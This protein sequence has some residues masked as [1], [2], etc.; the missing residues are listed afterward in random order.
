M[1]EGKYYTDKEFTTWVDTLATAINDDNLMIFVGAGVSI[2]QGYPNWDGYVSNFAHFWQFNIQNKNL[3]RKLNTAELNLFNEILSMPIS[4]KRKKDLL[5]T[6]IKKILGDDYQKYQLDFEK[7]YF[8]DVRPTN[9]GNKILSSLTKLRA[10]FITTNYDYEI[11]NHIDY[12]SSNNLSTKIHQLAA[13][14]ANKFK[15]EFV[16]NNVLHIHGDAEAVG[17]GFI[18]SSTSYV[19][20]YLRNPRKFNELQKWIK[21]NKPVILFVGSSMEEDEILALLDNEDNDAKN[22][23]F[24]KVDNQSRDALKLIKT[25]FRTNYNTDIFWYGDSFAQ[26][27]DE[28]GRLLEAVEKKLEISEDMSDWDVLHTPELESQK[29]KEMLDNHLSDWK[30]ISD[31]FRGKVDDNFVEN[32]LINI[33]GETRFIAVFNR[34]VM[35]WN[36]LAKHLPIM[37]DVSADNLEELFTTAPQQLHASAMY[38]AYSHVKAR[39]DVDLKRINGVLRDDVQLVE[40]PFNA[41]KDLMGKWLIAQLKKRGYI[42]VSEFN[43]DI[44]VNVVSSDIEEF[45][46]SL[47]TTSKYVELEMLLEENKIYSLL[48]DLLQMDNLY[49]DNNVLENFPD[50]VLEARIMQRFLVQ[51]DNTEGLDASIVTKLIAKIDFTDEIFGS[52][53][54]KFVARHAQETESKKPLDNYRDGIFDL[55]EMVMIQENSR[56]TVDEILADDIEVLSEKLLQ[57]VDQNTDE[58]SEI[59]VAGTERFILQQLKADSVIAQKLIKVLSKE[60]DKLFSSYKNLF[61]QIAQ[62][63]TLD[64]RLVDLSKQKILNELP[65]D[66]FSYELQAFFEYYIKLDAVDDAIMTGLLTI[67]TTILDTVASYGN[68]DAYMG[69]NQFVNTELGRYVTTLFDV[70]KS[71]KSYTQNVIEKVKNIEE[72]GFKEYIEGMVLAEDLITIPKHLTVSTLRGFT[73]RG[74]RITVDIRK[75]FKEVVQK[76]LTEGISIAFIERYVFPVMAYEIAPDTVQVKWEAFNFY[77]LI[78]SIIYTTESLPFEQQWL[79]TLLKN[80][81][82]D[83]IGRFLYLINEDD[84]ATN[85][86]ILFAKIVIQQIETHSNDVSIEGLNNINDWPEGKA[87][88]GIELFNLLLENKKIAK[89]AFDKLIMSR[90]VER[91]DGEQRQQLVVN[92]NLSTILSPLEI[93]DLRDEVAK[94]KNSD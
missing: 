39:N 67:D 81:T 43:D 59:T 30:F 70:T 3:D 38:T 48:Y 31:L 57:E 5:D 69:I 28:I 82:H 42:Y 4:N 19:D 41:D 14:D 92:S 62:D 50:S 1:S 61:M 78:R 51:L 7:Y 44:S 80:D 27:G 10:N 23:A 71:D 60:I 18:S 84:V 21:V 93:N 26:L 66:E 72:S 76:I 36:Y 25:F 6:H 52:E 56:I 65:S 13:F 86:L 8:S 9:I 88:I 68:D 77:N 54:N 37:D 35:F 53:L 2:N 90:L 75:A 29:F 33:L 15:K 17:N 87:R 89:G 94:L 74:G 11:E 46:E 22:I 73:F 47:N 91:M 83:Y 49:I 58:F 85:K 40:T 79:E 55:G 34:D 32:L 63:E 24:M 20:L 45:V 16:T 12:R 64:S